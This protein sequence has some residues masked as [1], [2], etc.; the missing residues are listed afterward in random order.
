M[1]HS[2]YPNALFRW[3]L[4]SYRSLVHARGSKLSMPKLY[5]DR[6]DAAVDERW[7]QSSAIERGLDSSIRRQVLLR[8]FQ[9]DCRHLRI[10]LL[11]QLGFA[12]VVSVWWRQTPVVLRLL[13]KVRKFTDPFCQ[14]QHK[15]RHP[16]NMPLPLRR[17]LQLE[18]SSWLP[19]VQ[20]LA[21]EV[22]P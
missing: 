16:L 13:F 9:L 20:L 3:S 7:R 6:L 19:V 5:H 22:Q 11:H 10:L 21:Y 4:A 1:K 17:R 18:R 14:F 12:A 15:R 8:L 2:S